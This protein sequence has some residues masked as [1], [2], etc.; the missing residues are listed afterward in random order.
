VT[1]VVMCPSA[2]NLEFISVRSSG[3]CVLGVYV[4]D[5]FGTLIGVLGSAAGAII[6]GSGPGDSTLTFGSG[7]RLSMFGI[8]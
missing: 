6:L 8:G 5:A 1:Y 3:S 2:S 4:A 7:S